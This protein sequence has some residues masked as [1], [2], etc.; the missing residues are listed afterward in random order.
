MTGASVTATVLDFLK[1]RVL[2]G[3]SNFTYIVLIPKVKNPTKMTQFRPISLCNVIYKIG[4]KTLANRL[5][6]VL[7]DMIS[8]IQLPFVPNR[9][10]TYKVLIAFKLNNYMN[11]KN[12]SRDDYMTFKLDVS[13]AYDRVDWMF[14]RKV[15][16]RLGLNSS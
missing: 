8:P 7:P 6:S 4:S 13:K 2:L 10:I 16:L 5:K 15:I 12:R 1:H 14:L 9:L 3:P 11:T